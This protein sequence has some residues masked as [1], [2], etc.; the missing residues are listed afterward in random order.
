MERVVTTCARSLDIVQLYKW[1][2]FLERPQN[3]RLQGDGDVNQVL[4]AVWDGLSIEEKRTGLLR[5]NVFSRGGH[6]YGSTV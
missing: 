5:R 4:D 1:F 6:I 3:F 2:I